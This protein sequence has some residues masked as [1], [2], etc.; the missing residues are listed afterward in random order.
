MGAIGNNMSREFAKN[1]FAK[2][3]SLSLA[4]YGGLSDQKNE[5]IFSSLKETF[6]HSVS[7]KL[8]REIT[9]F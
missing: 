4:N 2:R 9:L 5:L 3:A 1:I 8:L 6:I 7:N